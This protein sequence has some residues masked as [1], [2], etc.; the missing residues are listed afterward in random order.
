MTIELLLESS[1]Y[2]WKVSRRETNWKGE[3]INRKPRNICATIKRWL[4]CFDGRFAFSKLRGKTN[5]SLLTE[6]EREQIK[7][8][9]NPLHISAL[10]ANAYFSVRYAMRFKIECAW[11]AALCSRRSKIKTET[12]CK[13]ISWTKFLEMISICARV[14]CVH[15]QWF[16]CLFLHLL[17]LKSIFLPSS[18]ILRIVIKE[19]NSWERQEEIRSNA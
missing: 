1:V 12:E 6:L 8:C 9:S 2:V 17:A 11:V 10:M 7:S 16:V 5:R 3:K 18:Y 4:Q 14:L 13:Q 19:K 15:S